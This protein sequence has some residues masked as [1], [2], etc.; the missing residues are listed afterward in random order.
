D[1]D[2][3]AREFGAES[4]RSSNSSE[5]KKRSDP[6]ARLGARIRGRG[7]F[8]EDEWRNALRL[9]RP[10]RWANPHAGRSPQVGSC[11]GYST[12]DFRMGGAFVRRRSQI[13]WYR[14]VLLSQR[15]INQC[16]ER[17]FAQTDAPS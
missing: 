11:G 9:L 12:L 5:Q 7:K 13:T 16:F 8:G 14:E 17:R 2:D 6:F 1:A 10:T 3:R 15:P 4:S